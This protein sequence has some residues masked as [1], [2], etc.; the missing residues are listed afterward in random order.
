MNEVLR[1]LIRFLLG[2]EIS[3]VVAEAIGYTTDRHQFGRY[4][5][6]IYPSGFFDESVYGTA[7][8][9]P[10]LPLSSIEGVPLLFG[11]PKM[12][13]EGDTCV[14]YADLLASTYFLMTRYE[15]M[16][17]RSVRDTHGRFPGRESLPYRAGFIHRPVI[18]EYRLLLRRWLRQCQVRV[19][20]V[21]RGVRQVYLTHDVDAPFRYR[22]WK[23][24][25][26]S[27]LEGRGILRSLQSKFGSLE[28]DPY[29][30]FPWIFRQDGILEDVLGRGRCHTLL[31][32]RSGGRCVEDKPYYN[33]RSSDMKQLIKEAHLHRIKFGLHASYQAGLSPTEVVQERKIL[34]IQ[35]GEPIRFNRNHYLTSREPEDLDQLEAAGITDDFTMGYADVSGFRLGTARPVRWINP[36]TRRISTL[37]L[38]PL[39]IMDCSLDEPKYM[40]LDYPAALNYC[41]RL[42][43][44]VYDTGGEVVLLWH[45]TSFEEPAKGYHRKLYLQLLNELGKK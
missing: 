6:V 11:S 17:R 28:Q 10:T 18:D 23:G 41:S 31:F 24:L 1:Y 44:Q 3:E 2:E 35:V 16:L 39:L 27:L 4:S 20:D 21:E 8:S 37:R 43:D 14:V 12:E 26:R 19:P 22:S 38:H 34:E 25:V 33:L 40:G 42:I 32:L 15:E 7:R 5:L 29:Y 45:N 30:T 13:W 36:V 9:L